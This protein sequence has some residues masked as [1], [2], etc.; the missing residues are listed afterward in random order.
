MNKLTV[1]KHIIG[2]VFTTVLIS[3]VHSEETKATHIGYFEGK[4]FSSY[5]KTFEGTTKNLRDLDVNVQFP[6]SDACFTTDGTKKSRTLWPKYAQ[7]LLARKDLDIIFA[8]GTD[9]TRELLKAAH[10]LPPTNP[11][12]DLPT[13]VV[14]CC[15]SDAIKSNFVLNAT[16]SGI[17]NFTVRI[18]PERY[19]RM[20][21][22]FH[23]E[24]QFKKLGIIYSDSPDGKQF[25]NI[26]DAQ[27]VAKERGF[28]LELA[29]LAKDEEIT[30]EVC[31]NALESLID[32]G[33]DAFYLS[34][35]TCFEWGDPAYDTMQH[36][37]YLKAR[38]IPVLARQGTRDIKAG[39]LMGLST[40]D[41]SS[42]SRFMTERLQ[43]VMR[44]EKPRNAPMVDPSPPKVALNMTTAEAV[45]MTP[46]TTLLEMVSEIY[47]DQQ[48]PENAKSLFK[49]PCSVD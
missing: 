47:V 10:C 12:C 5:I 4:R 41:F 28:E 29:T 21:R 19:T 44:G 49:S 33:I 45:G 30:A 2:F 23:D 25:A 14:S 35:F 32:K 16:D 6:A 7:A 27:M 20:F 18:V 42:R 11:D 48:P 8:A 13:P 22:I 46:S 3:T 43:E 1:I 31:Q 39:A 9:A 15:V 34:V 36:L 24:L 37:T 17:D 40:I 38:K 26:K